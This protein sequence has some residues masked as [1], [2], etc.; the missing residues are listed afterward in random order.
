MEAVLIF[1]YIYVFVFGSC[2]A[3]FMNVVIYRLPLELDF[4]K[5]RSF[6]PK[7]RE[8]LKPY[9]MIP[10]LSWFLLKGKC[11]FC[12]ES[13]SFRY[14]VIEF[15]GGAL[16]VLCF[17]KYGFDWMTIISFSFSM[18]LLCICMIDYDTM[19]IPNSL[20][21]CC[22]IVAILSV[23]FLDISL[24]DRVIGFFII[25]VPLYLMNLIIPDC[26]GGGDIKLLAACGL[27]L[28]WSNLL[29]GMFIA[30]LMAGGYAGYLMLTH[31]I[32]RKGHIAFGPYICIGGFIALLYGQELL[33]WYLGL[34]G[35]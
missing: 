19:I 23:P 29:V 35:L 30:V 22:L 6:C 25:S 7:C 9:D 33:N 15:V 32:D 10:V 5:G 3:S 20:V 27:L 16:G 26:F 13:I 14:P 8:T 34:F 28:G 18:I 24:M 21:I 4:V 1:L 17:Y 11:R 12:H 31:K 2:V